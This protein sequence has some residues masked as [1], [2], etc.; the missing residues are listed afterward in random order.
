M[1]YMKCNLDTEHNTC[2][3]ILVLC[4]FIYITIVL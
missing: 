2:I 3:V 4:E 1:F